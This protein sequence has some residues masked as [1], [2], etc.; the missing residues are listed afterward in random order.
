MPQ[1]FRYV[2]FTSE[3]LSAALVYDLRACRRTVPPGFV[4]S[5]VLEDG[6]TIS[7]TLMCVMDNGCDMPIRFE[8]HEVLR[9]L[10]VYCGH[11]KIP[12]PAKA[13]KS[14]EIRRNRIALVCVI[15]PKETLRP[16]K[17]R[18][19]TV[20]SR[21]ATEAPPPAHPKNVPAAKPRLSPIETR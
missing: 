4:K 14:L 2:L 3:E 12:L 1:E 6:V 8:H 7:A 15:T 17:E 19:E 5:I 13:V 11:R 20:V 16:E 9:A 21:P 18:I 10:V